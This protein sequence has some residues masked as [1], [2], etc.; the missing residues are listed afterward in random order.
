MNLDTIQFDQVPHLDSLQSFL[1]EQMPEADI[2]A[3]PV[4]PETLD[5]ARTLI[6]ALAEQSGVDVHLQQGMLCYGPVGF[7]SEHALAVLILWRLPILTA[8]R[9]GFVRRALPDMDMLGK[10]LEESLYL[11]SLRPSAKISLRGTLKAVDAV[12]TDEGW[13]DKQLCD[14]KARIEEHWPGQGGGHYE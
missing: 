7:V 8:F 13:T 5:H 14:Y 10:P 12:A 9:W 3:I 2:R 11:E 1:R 6:E 4:T